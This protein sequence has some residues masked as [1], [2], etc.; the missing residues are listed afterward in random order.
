MVEVTVFIVP[1]LAAV[2]I[3]VLLF[4]ECTGSIGSG[5]SK[6]EEDETRKGAKLLRRDTSFRSS[7]SHAQK[8]RYKSRYNLDDES[9]LSSEVLN[10]T[11]II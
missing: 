5:T 3:V 10:E 4:C 9:E 2:L 11:L 7:I 8:S 6:V 1:L